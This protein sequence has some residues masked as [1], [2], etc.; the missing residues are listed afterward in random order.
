MF[1]ALATPT[2]RFPEAVTRVAQKIIDLRLEL[3]A[4]LLLELH[5]PLTTAAHTG[6]VIFGPLLLPL[7]GANPVQFLQTL[8]SDREHV[9]LLL[10]EIHRLSQPASSSEPTPP[11]T[12]GVHGAR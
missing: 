2:E 3:P 4:T 11:F 6:A 7:I 8:L 1:A 5:L 12:S 10:S 9:K